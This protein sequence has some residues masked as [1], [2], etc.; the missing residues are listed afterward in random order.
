[1]FYRLWSATVLGVNSS[2]IEIEV[3]LKKG[4]PQQS[5][6]GL[7][8]PAVKEA[9]E[10][11][12]SAIRNSGYNFPL[13]K[14]TINLAPADIKKEGSIFDLAMAIGILA[15]SDQIEIKQKIENFIILGE[16]ALDG[17]VRPIHGVLSI[18][19][20]ARETNIHNIIL[21]FNNYKEASL[22]SGLCI[23]PIKYLR[24][25]VQIIS[26]NEK[27]I[28]STLNSKDNAVKYFHKIK[29]SKYM[30]NEYNEDFSEVRG[31]NYAVRAVEIAAAG[32]H[33]I[34]LIGSPGSGK[35]MIASRIPTIIPG[36]V[37][38]ESI[39]TTKIYSIAGLLPLEEGLINKRPFRAPLLED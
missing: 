3:D 11:V 26:G 10:R 25:A 24:D 6:V 2:I 7:P 17:F 15:V 23:Y 37:E 29:Y 21:P 13:G 8:D 27:N 36:M 16:L 18:L 30:G 19:E 5:I 22:I 39:E 4:L 33:N 34:L 32:G 14:L 35:T 9:K 28:K 31:Q 12:N 20:N 1:M 38:K